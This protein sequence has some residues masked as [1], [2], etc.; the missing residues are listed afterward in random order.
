M[1][2]AE[3]H[4]GRSSG[5]GIGGIWNSSSMHSSDWL[6]MFINFQVCKTSVKLRKC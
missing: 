5:C 6:F 2:V 4:S 1:M 3:S